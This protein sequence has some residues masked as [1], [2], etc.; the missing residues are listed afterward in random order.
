MV[1][2]TCPIF[3]VFY[4]GKFLIGIKKTAEIFVWSYERNVV[5]SLSGVDAL[6]EKGKNG[7][8]TLSCQSQVLIQLLLWHSNRQFHF[9]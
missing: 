9:Q 1:L 5:F 4:S 6:K 8:R 7:T 3:S 2:F